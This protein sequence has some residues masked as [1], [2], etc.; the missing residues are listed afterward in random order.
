MA[1]LSLPPALSRS[2]ETEGT[3]ATPLHTSL[4]AEG[5]AGSDILIEA[6]SSPAT[7]T[8][9][10]VLVIER[11]IVA[12]EAAEAAIPLY[13]RKRRL[14]QSSKSSSFSSLT[15]LFFG[16]TPATASTRSGQDGGGNG[17]RGRGSNSG[18]DRPKLQALVLTKNREIAASVAGAEEAEGH[19]EGQEQLEQPQ[20][21]APQA[22][23]PLVPRS[24][25][26]SSLREEEWHMPPV[27]LAALEA[28]GVVLPTPLQ[29]AVWKGGRGSSRA[30]LIVHGRPGDETATAFCVPVLE[31]V[32]ERYPTSLAPSKAASAE[33][34][35]RAPASEAATPP[36]EPESYE[37]VALVL[38]R[39]REM[40]ADIAETL[41]RLG[42]NI[43]SL[44]VATLIGGVPVAENHKALAD[45]C[46]V[47]VGTPGRV[48]F[49]MKEG[50]LKVSAAKTLVLDSADWLMATVFQ[51]D[52]GWIAARF[53][54]DKQ[55]LAFSGADPKTYEAGLTALVGSSGMTPVGCR[56]SSS[57]DAAFASTAMVLEQ[58]EALAA[59]LTGAGAAGLSPAQGP[60]KTTAAERHAAAVAGVDP[61]SD[62]GRRR[63]DGGAAGGADTAARAATTTA[64][65]SAP[66]YSSSSAAGGA[67]ADSVV[68]GDGAGGGE[69]ASRV[70]RHAH[71]PHPTTCATGR[72]RFEPGTRVAVGGVI[73]PPGRSATSAAGAGS[74][75]SPIRTLGMMREESARRA[76]GLGGYGSYMMGGAGWAAAAA[77]PTSA[78]AAGA[79]AAAAGASSPPSFLARGAVG[80]GGGGGGGGGRGRKGVS[81]GSSS[82]AS[83]SSTCS[84]LRARVRSSTENE[85]YGA[86]CA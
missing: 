70:R 57:T 59:A 53:P 7:A 77:A 69:D 16:T 34:P 80:A 61:V 18:V 58:G 63:G 30:D 71:A 43:P 22:A 28:D 40:A 14:Q 17:D 42:R 15:Q 44:S 85:I 78:T 36:P 24:S 66:S 4:W 1:S 38:T 54:K 50:S 81:V 2:L 48:K 60:A 31:R 79:A 47:A 73:W 86:W 62:G 83:T 33:M 45:G 27:L 21:Q 55:V 52:V 11:L 75:A 32:L 10:A 51:D 82:T 12:L 9:L 76:Q 56:A 37:P 19:G 20:E 68:G 72:S 25:S 41:A 3:E 13:L 6:A 39:T 23:L 5:S 46:N 49:L 64:T 74:K 84:A 26:S 29:E 65:V 67:A 35:A 8:A